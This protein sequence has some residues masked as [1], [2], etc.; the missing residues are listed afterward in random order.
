MQL[1]DLAAALDIS[2]AMVSKLRRRGMPVD[3][4]AAAERWRRRHLD[5]VRTKGVRAGTERARHAQ[6]SGGDVSK[7]DSGLRRP[8]TVDAATARL[9]RIVEEIGRAAFNSI[10]R[11]AFANLAP[12]LRQAMSQVPIELRERIRLP[13]AAWDALTAAIPLD[14]QPN[15]EQAVAGDLDDEFMGTFWY[16]IALGELAD[17]KLVPKEF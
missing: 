5:F 16:Q 15:T 2:P 6:E 13:L 10:E 12:V 3:S 7:P 8:V 17:M 1:K 11:G 14:M 9:L 4:V